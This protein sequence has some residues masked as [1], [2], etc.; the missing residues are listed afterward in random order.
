[1][2]SEGGQ[3]TMETKDKELTDAANAEDKKPKPKKRKSKQKLSPRNGQET[4]SAEYIEKFDD[5]KNMSNNVKSEDK[6]VNHNEEKAKTPRHKSKPQNT[7]KDV[8]GADVEN[9]EKEIK[10]ENKQRQRRKLQRKL[11]SKKRSKF[12]NEDRLEELKD[13]YKKQERIAQPN[14]DKIDDTVQPCEQ[15]KHTKQDKDTKDNSDQDSKSKYSEQSGERRKK[16]ARARTAKRRSQRHH[17]SVDSLTSEEPETDRLKY[18]AK[19]CEDTLSKDNETTQDD[20]EPELAGLIDDQDDTPGYKAYQDRENKV[21][22]ADTKDNTSS[23]E[24]T[25]D[26]IVNHAKTPL[27][28]ETPG[29]V[30]YLSPHTSKQ[31]IIFQKGRRQ[32]SHSSVMRD[33]RPGN[34]KLHSS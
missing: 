20:L 22:H 29:P 9:I 26:Y 34:G 13:I 19:E 32:V 1:M 30:P 28:P 10:D 18:N 27:I 23:D 15:D 31:S 5:I 33:L 25:R 4:Q 3:E 24:L 12:D 14:Q 16:S 2:N 17:V 11:S 21:V 6:E 7:V 8:Y